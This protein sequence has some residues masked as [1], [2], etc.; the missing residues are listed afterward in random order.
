MKSLL[1]TTALALSLCA[2]ALLN[3]SDKLTDMQLRYRHASLLERMAMK[4][5]LDKAIAE[6]QAFQL[7]II[8]GE[9]Q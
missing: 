6:Y 4:P 9:V 3:G 5:A 2:F 8:K 1:T 7:K